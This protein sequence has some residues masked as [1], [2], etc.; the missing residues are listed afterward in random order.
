[1]VKNYE[2]IGIVIHM[3]KLFVQEFKYV[4]TKVCSRSRSRILP[5]EDAQVAAQRIKQIMIIKGERYA[6]QETRV[7]HC[8]ISVFGTS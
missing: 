8:S 6:G 1:M 5:R 4:S 2:V 3:V 7:S